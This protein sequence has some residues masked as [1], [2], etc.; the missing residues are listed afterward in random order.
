MNYINAKERIAELE[1]QLQE[2]TELAE[3]LIMQ[4]VCNLVLEDEYDQLK[5]KQ[6][7]GIK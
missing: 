2:M 5:A 3:K 7:R 6:R 4:E 1:Q